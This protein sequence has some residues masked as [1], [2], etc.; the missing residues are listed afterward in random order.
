MIVVYSESLLT[1][2]QPTRR[3]NLEEHSIYIPNI[4][5]GVFSAWRQNQA[6]NTKEITYIISSRFLLLQ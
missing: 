5:P 2:R 3:I 6:H 1:V 4:I